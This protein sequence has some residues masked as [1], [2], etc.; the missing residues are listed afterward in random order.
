MT[1]LTWLFLIYDRNPKIE[2]YDLSSKNVIVFG[3]Q[4]FGLR[5]GIQGLRL[6]EIERVHHY[7]DQSSEPKVRE[8]VE[9]ENHFSEFLK[10]Q[11]VKAKNKLI[12]PT[13]KNS[14]KKENAYN[15]YLKS[16]YKRFLV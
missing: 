15:G 3:T 2:F 1:F 11:P 4:H 14:C 10:K 13:I 8:V 5:V 16:C 7:L 9:F 6:V 12:Q